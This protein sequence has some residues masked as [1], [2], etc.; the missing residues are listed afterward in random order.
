MTTAPPP[1]ARHHAPGQCCLGA[2]V[3]YLLLGEHAEAAS[4]FTVAVEHDPADPRA[5]LNRARAHGGLGRFD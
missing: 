1:G 4:L 3:C 2:G 5:W